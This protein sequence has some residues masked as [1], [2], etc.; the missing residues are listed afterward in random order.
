MVIVWEREGGMEMTTVWR[1]M[2]TRT[3]FWRRTTGRDRKRRR[4]RINNIRFRRTMLMS[5]IFWISSTGT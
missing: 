3:R 4:R 2:R 1:T 5:V